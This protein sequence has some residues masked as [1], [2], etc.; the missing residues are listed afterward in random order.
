MI[1]DSTRQAIAT[2]LKDTYTKARIGLGGNSTSPVATNLDVPLSNVIATVNSLSD[3][4]VVD[5]KFTVAGS[6]ISGLT[7]REIAIFNKTYDN[8]AGTT[9]AEYTEMLTRINF[10]GIGPFSS[11]DVDFFV[12]IEVE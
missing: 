10:E 9:I 7:I 5:F 8:S 12:T 2:H 1:T 6:S 11:G 3:L 4:N